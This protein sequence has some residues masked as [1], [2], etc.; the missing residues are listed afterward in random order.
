MGI[1][2]P[3]RWLSAAL[4]LAIVA[5]VFIGSDGEGPAAAVERPA[6]TG[7]VASAD[8]APARMDIALIPERLE[9]RVI[10]PVA[11]DAFAVKSWAPP[12]PP[13]PPPPKVA[14]KPVVVAPPKPAAPALPF[15]YLGRL[16]EAGKTLF[17][18]AAGDQFFSAKVGQDLQG[19]Y[20]LESVGGNVLNFTYLPL[21]IMQ[22]MTVERQD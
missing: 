14:P 6:E 10:E 17:F 19:N 11:E 15:R 18:L 9:P 13:P 12:L 7:R 8:A 3:G 2:S 4:V 22:T 5:V 21:N 20:R 1:R 16:E